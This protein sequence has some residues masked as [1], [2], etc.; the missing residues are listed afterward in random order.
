MHHF[1]EKGIINDEERDKYLKS[2]GIQVLRFEN[3]LIMKRLETVLSIIL[4]EIQKTP[5]SRASISPLG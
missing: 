4:E 3:D 2:F 5:L 1:S